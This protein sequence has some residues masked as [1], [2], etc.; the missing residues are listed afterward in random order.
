MRTAKI[1]TI[2]Y[3]LGPV[4]AELARLALAR[5][6]FEVMAAI[7]PHPARAGKDLGAL[8]NNQQIG[9]QIAY[10]AE[11]ILRE[12]AADVVLHTSEVGLS[13]I[14]TQIAEAAAS[15]MNVVSNCAELAFPNLRYPDIAERLR[16]AAVQAGVCILA[17]GDSCGYMMDVLPAVLAT[18]CQEVRS[19]TVKRRM[20]IGDRLLELREQAGIGFTREGF[21]RAADEGNL[22]LRGAVE[23]VALVADTLGWRSEGVKESIEPIFA[24][25]QMKTSYLVVEKRQV[26]GIRQKAVAL[27]GDRE[28]VQLQIELSMAVEEPRE[29]VIVEGTPPISLVLPAGLAETKASAALMVNSAVAIAWGRYQ[30]LLSLRDL[31]LAP[32]RRPQLAPQQELII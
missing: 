14:Y 30:G 16:Q 9:I 28:V 7:D 24:T 27:V 4:G 31:P 12:K 19:V 26:M 5:R 21:Q 8:V 15:Q 10:D 1:R 11:T 3:G 20:S 17:A 22:G 18:A 29:E 23:S 2:L 25:K 32:Y 13:S 6:D